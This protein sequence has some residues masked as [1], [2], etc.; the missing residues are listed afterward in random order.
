[1]GYINVQVGGSF[2]GHYGLNSVG[3]QFGA[4]ENGHADAVAQAIEYLA[5]TVLPRAIALDHQLHEEGAKPDGG[6][7][8]KRIRPSSQDTP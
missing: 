6:F 2:V 8:S 4:M 7:T 1:M 3:E 5:A